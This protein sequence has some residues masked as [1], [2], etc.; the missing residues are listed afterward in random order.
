MINRLTTTLVVYPVTIVYVAGICV[1][2]AAALG[3][4]P[5]PH[6]I[7]AL[8][9][10]AIVAALIAVWR[11]MHLVHRLVNSQRDELLDRIGVLV[12]ALL[13]SG[14]QIPDTEKRFQEAKGDLE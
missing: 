6:G 9:F 4:L 8:T 10:A 13:S 7:I 1:L 12:G 2:I 3:Y 11:E 14:V 5:V